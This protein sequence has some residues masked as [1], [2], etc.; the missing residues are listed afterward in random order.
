MR[1]RVQRT[2]HADPVRAYA[3]FSNPRAYAKAHASQCRSLTYR[4]DSRTTATTREIWLYAGHAFRLRHRVRLIPP[5]RVEL[6]TID[7]LGQGARERVQL[8][9][10][11]LGTRVRYELTFSLPGDRD[12]ILERVIAPRVRALVAGLADED[13]LAI[14]GVPDSAVKGG[15]HGHQGDKEE[16]AGDGSLRRT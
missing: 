8:E 10:A 4:A 15:R 1:V 3:H 5:K 6:D 12:G 14:E 9:R 16:V 2:V 7:G 11:P 13:V